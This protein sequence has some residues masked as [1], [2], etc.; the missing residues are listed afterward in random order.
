MT[1]RY[2][3]AIFDSV[4][5]LALA[6]WVGSILFFSFAVAPIIFRVL[7][8]EAGGRFVRAL[9]P[10]YYTW[11]AVS[12]AVALPAAI[13]VPLSFPELRGPAVAVQALTILA[14][15][16]I[17]L[18]AGNS[19]TPAINAA[20]DAGPA[21][22]ARFDRLHRRSV[23]LNAV[24]LVLG[25]GLLVAFANRPLPK[26]PGILEPTPVERARA[27]YQRLRE[28]EEAGRSRP[29]RGEPAPSSSSSPR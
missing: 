3:L 14:G 5:V 29:A 13:A 2:L 18:Y 6:A 7:G 23:R 26:T 8:T 15:T 20:R 28:R 17:M 19:L 24:A 9:F 22:Q 11:G 25:V 1:A 27:E 21:G 16:L 12:G 10:R 4:Y